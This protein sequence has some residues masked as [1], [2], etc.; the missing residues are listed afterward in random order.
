MVA[1][2]REFNYVCF[3]IFLKTFTYISVAYNFIYLLLFSV[4]ICGFLK[5]FFYP[6]G[7]LRRTRSPLHTW[8]PWIRRCPP[9][10]ITSASYS[11][12]SYF[13]TPR[14]ARPTVSFHTLFLAPICLRSS[15]S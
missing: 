2:R 4:I 3:F 5:F 10:H 12:P 15:P 7:S 13:S 6:L 11:C 1:P 9:D 14:L 8:I